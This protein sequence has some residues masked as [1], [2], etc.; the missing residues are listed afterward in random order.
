MRA[1]GESENAWKRGE[2]GDTWTGECMQCALQPCNNLVDALAESRWT[3]SLAW[4]RIM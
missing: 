4:T 2:L 1:R 3:P